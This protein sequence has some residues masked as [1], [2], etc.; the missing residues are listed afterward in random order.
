MEET[1][2]TNRKKKQE[3]QGKVGAPVTQSYTQPVQ[4]PQRE[5]QKEPERQPER[6]KEVYR[7]EQPVQKQPTKPHCK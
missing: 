2:S 1:N 4:R 3:V 5:F 6:E 7:H